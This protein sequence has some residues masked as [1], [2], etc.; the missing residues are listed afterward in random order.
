M[1]VCITGLLCEGDSVFF[2]EEVT[3]AL[4]GQVACTRS[5]C[6]SGTPCRP[7]P[8]EERSRS[9]A[10]CP[11]PRLV[12]AAPIRT[13]DSESGARGGSEVERGSLAYLQALS[14]RVPG[15]CPSPQERLSRRGGPGSAL[16]EAGVG[17]LTPPTHSRGGPAARPQ[18]WVIKR[19]AKRR[20]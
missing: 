9:V 20:P 10:W 8:A 13:R 2:S 19:P 18:L 1:Y 11:S 12:P 14:L 5:Y 16:S 17:R 7:C 3:G 15:R 4:G 6:E